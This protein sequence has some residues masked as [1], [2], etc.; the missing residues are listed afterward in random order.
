MPAASPPKPKPPIR[1][2]AGST[3]VEFAWIRD[4]WQHGVVSRLGRWE[5]LEGEAD[6]RNDPR[7]PA[8]P[9]LVEVSLV[10]LAGGPAILGVGL[11]GRSHF[12]L[13]VATCSEETD[14]LLFEAA[15]RIQEPAAWIG[16]TYADSGGRIIRLQAAS[17]A[18]PATLSWSYRIGPGGVTRCG[19][20]APSA[21]A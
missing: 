16:S 21:R 6:G 14:T 9:V 11:A 1:L 4:R 19:P 8:S 17:V 5:S 3:V 12:S 18:P 20:D 15:C 13:S 2:A 10:E 7:W